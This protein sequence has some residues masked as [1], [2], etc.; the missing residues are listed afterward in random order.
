MKTKFCE[1]AC[2]SVLIAENISQSA[3]LELEQVNPDCKLVFSDSKTNTESL[4]T[5]LKFDLILLNP[6]LAGESFFQSVKNSGHINCNVPVIALAGTLSVPQKQSL[7]ADGFDDCQVLPLTAKNF[8]EVRNLWLGNNQFEAVLNSIHKLLAK[9]NNNSLLV[10]T[11]WEHL[12]AELPVQ[13]LLF[14]EALEH[15]E[16]EN[17]YEIIHKMNGSV[18]ICCL[19]DIEFLTGELERCLIVK[20]HE[21]LNHN[22]RLLNMELAYLLNQQQQIFNYLKK[23]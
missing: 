13:M 6:T 18:K 2:F 9:V 22:S 8:L 16:F 23:L 11:L 17:A 15:R 19:S 4:L 12:L 20:Q 3:K 1:S 5:R 21:T 10:L 7:I 14:E